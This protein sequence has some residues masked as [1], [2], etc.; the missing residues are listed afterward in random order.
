M[1]ALGITLVT[2]SSSVAVAL[3]E[4]F[5]TEPR[6]PPHGEYPVLY[7]SRHVLPVLSGAPGPRSGGHPFY[8]P[9]ASRNAVGGFGQPP[10]LPVRVRDV[11]TASRRRRGGGDSASAANRMAPLA[12]H[13]G[14][15][16]LWRGPCWRARGIALHVGRPHD[17]GGRSNPPPQHLPRGFAW[18]R[19]GGGAW[20]VERRSGCCRLLVWARP[21]WGSRGVFRDAPLLRQQAD[22]TAALH[23]RATRLVPSPGAAAGQRR[24][25]PRAQLLLVGRPVAYHGPPRRRRHPRR[26][27]DGRLARA[28]PTA[29]GAPRLAR[30]TSGPTTL[31]WRDVR[32]GQATRLFERECEPTTRAAVTVDVGGWASPTCSSSR[33]E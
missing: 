10:R 30:R 3:V 4:R 5:A 26:R 14:P 23:D 12:C 6:S 19:L 27:M 21:A 7:I 33:R 15:G 8:S 22:T 11:A 18:R 2:C 20:W 16:I 32:R 28:A 9:V 1:S 25:M 24:A 31:V 13:G 17:T 29:P